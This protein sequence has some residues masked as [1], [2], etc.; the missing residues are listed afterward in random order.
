MNFEPMYGGA[1]VICLGADKNNRTF[2]MNLKE[3]LRGVD[4]VQENT[5]E[6][7]DEVF[8]DVIKFDPRANARS[9]TT[10]GEAGVFLQPL[11]EAVP[12][13]QRIFGGPTCTQ[14]EAIQA[15]SICQSPS[16]SSTFAC[17]IALTSR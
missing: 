2:S 9:L 1:L 3:S 6:H 8:S 4:F 14:G 7:T 11:A 17:T 13:P 10:R 12:S 15:A 16:P 5:P